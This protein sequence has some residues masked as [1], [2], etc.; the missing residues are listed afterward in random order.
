MLLTPVIDP[1]F[2]SK[3]TRGC[4]IKTCLISDQRCR[5]IHQNRNIHYWTVKY[6]QNLSLIICLCSS[7][8]WAS[9]LVDEVPCCF[10][11]RESFRQTD[12]HVGN[13]WACRGKLGGGILGVCVDAVRYDGNA[14]DRCTARVWER[15]CVPCGDGC[16]NALWL[17]HCYNDRQVCVWA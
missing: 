6:Y 10:S 3:G 7:T 4:F 12:P 5:Q 15:T 17:C 2:V 1:G 13:T 8:L 11:I 9:S 14:S 16:R